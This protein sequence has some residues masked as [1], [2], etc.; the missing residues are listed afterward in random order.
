MEH[1][2]LDITKANFGYTANRGVWQESFI[3]KDG[4]WACK[5]ERAEQASKLKEIQ[6]FSDFVNDW[7]NLG[8]LRARKW[9]KDTALSIKK[10]KYN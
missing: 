5:I 1:D 7:P 8:E 9:E 10:R 3:T 6:P 2:T 4:A